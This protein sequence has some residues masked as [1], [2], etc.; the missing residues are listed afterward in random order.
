MVGW[1]TRGQGESIAGG[2]GA[3]SKGAG[4]KAVRVTVAQLAGA[5]L[6][7]TQHWPLFGQAVRTHGAASGPC[8]EQ[9]S[10]PGALRPAWPDNI[11][12]LPVSC[13][14]RT[15]LVTQIGQAF[16]NSSYIRRYIEQE[17][18]KPANN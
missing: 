6:A 9:G 12:Y 2:A 1:K 16:T 5:V 17:T 15:G 11:R 8:P 7:A 10:P 14:A 18:K 4:G 3:A 13:L